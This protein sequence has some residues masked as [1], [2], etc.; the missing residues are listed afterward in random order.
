MVQ[1]IDQP[2]L[3]LETLSKLVLV[4]RAGLEHFE[5]K[6]AVFEYIMDPIDCT[7]ISVVELGL[8]AKHIIDKLADLGH[9]RHVADSL[10]EAS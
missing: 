6:G 7:K 1:A 5:R 10:A 9:P 4:V 2:C 8:D 3:T